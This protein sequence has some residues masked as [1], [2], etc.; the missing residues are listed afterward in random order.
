VATTTR[1]VTADH[2]LGPGLDP[3]TLVPEAAFAAV[4]PVAG[5]P[6]PVGIPGV[7]SLVRRQLARLFGGSGPGRPGG[8]GLLPRDAVSWHVLA[9]PASIAG[10]VRSLLL[11]ATHP[12]AMAGVVQHSRFESDPLGRLAGTSAWVTVA[13]FG[14]AEEA[15]RLARTIRGMHRG[16]RGHAPD[17]RR[18]AADDAEL[19]AW[20]QS[21]LTAS[22]LATHQ[23]FA[24]RPLSDG[25]ADR[26]VL[27]QSALGAVLDP[28]IDLE[29]VRPG[30]LEAAVTLPLLAEG[31]LATDRRS[32]AQA[33]RAWAPD[34]VVGDDARDTVAFLRSAPLP[35]TVRAAY[36]VLLEG[37][38]ATLPASLGT[39]LGLGQGATRLRAAAG[40]VTAMRAGVGLSP[41]LDAARA[42]RP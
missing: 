26:F 5:L 22:L 2:P 12:L 8:V 20:V 25:E 21:S 1:D 19:L 27:E 17:G 24:P 36:R 31:T 29:D 30:D 15:L 39:P 16:V 33:F 34:L 35:A 7:R 6:L 13:A 32:L 10:G 38:G 11:Q 14:S 28:R 41:S 42:N 40:L 9:E 37:V 4:R 23:L 3:V 18:Y